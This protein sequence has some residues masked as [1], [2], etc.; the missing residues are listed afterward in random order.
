MSCGFTH[1]AFANRSRGRGERLTLKFS[2]RWFSAS[3]GDRSLPSQLTR[4]QAYYLWYRVL[5]GRRKSATIIDGT[6]TAIVVL[7]MGT[8][9]AIVVPTMGTD[10]A[11]V[12]PTMG[13]DTAIVVPTMGTGSVDGGK[14]TPVRTI[15]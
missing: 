13:T 14:P 15:A 5:M 2:G 1:S 7:T 6:D 3:T 11:I 8:D 9:T 12:V 10:T 4:S